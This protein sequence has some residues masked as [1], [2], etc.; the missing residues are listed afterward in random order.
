MKQLTLEY[1]LV[2]MAVMIAVTY[3]LRV[4][5]LVLFRKK[6]NGKFIFSFLTY[7]PYGVL[8]AMI[9]PDIFLFNQPEAAFSPS[10]FICAAAGAAVALI[11]S[12]K[13]KGLTTVSLC[14]VATVFIV[15]QLFAY[16]L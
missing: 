8:A 3:G 16:F 6:L 14:A 12:I 1:L 7:T 10:A 11:L 13:K 4:V 2:C 9:F 15:Q 5:S